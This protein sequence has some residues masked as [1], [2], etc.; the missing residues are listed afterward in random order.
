MIN[1]LAKGRRIERLAKAWYEARSWRVYRPIWSR[2]GAK[3]IY[4][5]GDLLCVR[6]RSEPLLV[7]VRAR[8][9]GSPS[10]LARDGKCDACRDLV[11]C[12][13]RLVLLL[14]AGKRTKRVPEWEERSLLYPGEWVRTFP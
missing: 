5:W 9:G 11:G 1:A 3:D 12:G 6:P 7:Q 10:A 8:S 2:F 4:G 13:F 14:Y